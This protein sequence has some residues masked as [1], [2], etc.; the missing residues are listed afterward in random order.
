[1]KKISIYVSMIMMLTFGVS[2]VA[3][4]GSNTYQVKQGDTLWGISKKYHISVGQIKSWNKLS[5]DRIKPKQI[6]K[7]SA[8]KTAVKKAQSAP[9][10]KAA[11]YKEITVTA[12]AYT[13][14]CRGCSGITAT[15]LN[16]KKNPNAKAISV[17]PRIIPLGSKVYVPGYGYAVAADKGSAV[18]GNKIDVF[19]S[20]KSKAIQWG[21]KTVKIKVMK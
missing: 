4:A 17:D 19:I 13:A 14:S 2:G 5:S 12:T 7:L 11:S 16:L 15:G 6:L 21:R 1:M 10:V 3:S 8:A 20:S 9:K 18:K